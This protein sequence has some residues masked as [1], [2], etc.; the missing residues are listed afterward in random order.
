MRSPPGAGGRGATRS[1]VGGGYLG[2]LILCRLSPKLGMD[3]RSGQAHRRQI[4]PQPGTSAQTDRSVRGKTTDDLRPG[5]TGG[6]RDTPA[7]PSTVTTTRNEAN[8][9]TVSTVIS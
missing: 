3:I 2:P 1:G 5:R 6:H 7:Q 9:P 4:L 8:P